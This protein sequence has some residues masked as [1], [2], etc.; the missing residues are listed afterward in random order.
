[1]KTVHSTLRHLERYSR[2]Y[3]CEIGL[4]LSLD[5]HELRMAFPSLCQFN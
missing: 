1:M 2:G 4:S 5:L 3:N